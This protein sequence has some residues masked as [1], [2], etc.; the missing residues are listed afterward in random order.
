MYTRNKG[1]IPTRERGGLICRS[2]LSKVTCFRE[3]PEARQA[4][5]MDGTKD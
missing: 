4:E 5:S 2:S 1:K 3:V